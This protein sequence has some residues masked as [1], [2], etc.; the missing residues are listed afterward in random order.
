MKTLHLLLIFV[1]LF[2]ANR[3]VKLIQKR[4]KLSAYPV[5]KSPVL[6]AIREIGNRHRKT[7]SYK[8][9]IQ[10]NSTRLISEYV[11][12]DFPRNQ[13]YLSSIIIGEAN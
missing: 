12:N 4:K 8:A 9:H 10:T 11:W 2:I 7:N 13:P 3:V 6:K 1:G 5:P